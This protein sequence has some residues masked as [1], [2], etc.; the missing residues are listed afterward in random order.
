[1]A[2][3][4]GRG[5]VPRRRLLVPMGPHVVSGSYKTLRV[6]S[7]AKKRMTRLKTIALIGSTL[8]GAPGR[9]K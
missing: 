9:N 6:I 4:A 1:M 2:R 3:Q 8:A 7:R 5:F